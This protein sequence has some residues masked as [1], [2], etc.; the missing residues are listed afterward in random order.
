MRRSGRLAWSCRGC[1]TQLPRDDDD[2]D[3]DDGGQGPVKEKEK[4][5]NQI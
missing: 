5:S 3:D 1:N 2:D 4:K